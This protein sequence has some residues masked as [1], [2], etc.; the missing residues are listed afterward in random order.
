MTMIEQAAAWISERQAFYNWIGGFDLAVG[1]GR[2]RDGTMLR[3]RPLRPQDEPV[4]HDL[5]ANTSHEAHS[6]GIPALR[7]PTK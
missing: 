2:L 4:L 5:A 7:S 1:W 3:I 6:S